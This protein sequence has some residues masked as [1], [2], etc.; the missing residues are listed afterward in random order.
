MD[1][2][3]FAKSRLLSRWS[4]SLVIAA[5]STS[6]ALPASAND[7]AMSHA[8]AP[9]PTH[10]HSAAPKQLR[11]TLDEAVNL[12]LERQPTIHAARESLNSAHVSRKV[13][14]SPLSGFSP[15]ICYRRQ[16]ADLGVAIGEAAVEQV[17]LETINAVTRAYVSVL[18]A[19]EQLDLA[20][21]A[22]D[23]ISATRAAAKTLVDSGSKEVTKADLDRLDTFRK[24]GETRVGE[25]RV[26]VARAK[27]AVREAVGLR[28]DVELEIGDEKLSYLYDAFSAFEKQNGS[29]LSCRLAVKTAQ[30]KRPELV[31]ASLLA[32]I[33]CLEIDAQK[34]QH[35]CTVY[36]KTF[37]AT[38]D[39]HTRILP[40]TVING[41][42]RPGPVGP[43]MPVYLAGMA[44]DRAERARI[45]YQRSLAVSEKAT[46]LVTLEV[47]EACARL[48]EQVNQIQ[49]LEEAVAS[50]KKLAEDAMRI[51]REDQMPTEKLLTIQFLEAQANSSLNE[52]YF[53]FGQAIGLLQRA[54]AG[55]LWNC[56]EP[57]TS[58]NSKDASK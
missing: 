49:L 12:A 2:Q 14:N 26:G 33:H 45:L 20:Q 42:Y 58:A 47:E 48:K 50:A 43:E 56:F 51:Y 37:A 30:D 41:D 40:A 16:Q 1:R 18:F 28:D 19:R 57:T 36:A 24:L 9:A 31:Q 46:N 15:G 10:A 29:K 54:T 3:L 13:A 17:R 11:L 34:A 39:I 44:E 25:A 8:P 7:A 32:Q 52:A 38:S 53:K 5:L 21:K 23:R 22:V 4:R 55:E 6:L 27:A 35:P